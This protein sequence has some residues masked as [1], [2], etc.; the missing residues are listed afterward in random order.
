[1]TP[2]Q[3]WNVSRSWVGQIA[4]QPELRQTVFIL[5]NNNV[6][7]AALINETVGQTDLVEPADIPAILDCVIALYPPGKQTPGSDESIL[8]QPGA[9]DFP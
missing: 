4:T 3:I 9:P 2:E 1:V 7:L 6:A 5:G 8:N